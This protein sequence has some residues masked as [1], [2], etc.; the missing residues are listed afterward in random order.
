MTY[1]LGKINP[2]YPIVI[3]RLLQL[4]QSNQASVFHKRTVEY[5]KEVLLTE[6]LDLI[7]QSLKEYGLV[8]K[9]SQN[10]QQAHECYKL[11]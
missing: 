11:L 1:Q 5:L 9:P 7:V 8:S 10:I 4:L 6:Q 3:K 2:G